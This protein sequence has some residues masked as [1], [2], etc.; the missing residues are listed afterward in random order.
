MTRKIKAPIDTGQATAL[1]ALRSRATGP[2]YRPVALTTQGKGAFRRFKDHLHEEH[3]GLLPAWYAFCQGHEMVRENHIGEVHA[4][5][6]ADS[7]PQCEA[8]AHGPTPPMRST[9]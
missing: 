8:D 5:L 3:P 1:E 6:A 4:W 7:E 2:A 9:E